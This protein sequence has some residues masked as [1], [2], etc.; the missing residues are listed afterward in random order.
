MG[1]TRYEMNSWVSMSR[2]LWNELGEEGLETHFQAKLKSESVLEKNLCWRKICVGEIWQTAQFL[3]LM[4]NNNMLINFETAN[5]QS[6]FIN[7]VQM[8]YYRMLGPNQHSKLYKNA[9]K[10]S[11]KDNPWIY[12][13]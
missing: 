5:S 3:P 9:L 8:S 7:W 1:S 6:P 10:L 13:L 11:N 12:Y 2:S 4:V